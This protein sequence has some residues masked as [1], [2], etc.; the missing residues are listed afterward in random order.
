[1]N[2][3]RV[4]ELTIVVEELHNLESKRQWVGTNGKAQYEVKL[5]P[6]LESDDDN[7]KCLLLGG[8]RY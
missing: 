3:L 5:F 4:S 2:C 7:K 1:M 6:R 8:R